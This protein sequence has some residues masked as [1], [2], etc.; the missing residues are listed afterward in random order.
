VLLIR[1]PSIPA[2]GTP[3]M[4]AG[5]LATP[6]LGAT[7]VSV[8]RQRQEPGAINPL[9][10]HNREEVMVQLAGTVL[11]LVEDERVEL[12]PGDTL[13]VPANTLHQIENTG[14]VAAE[15]L[16]IAPTGVQFFRA[17]GEEVVPE[18]AQ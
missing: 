11:I 8:I 3:G 4:F 14:Q 1:N 2:S 16:L 15:W 18:W 6:R 17:S 9:H 10:S 13:I 5:G 7:K 12:T